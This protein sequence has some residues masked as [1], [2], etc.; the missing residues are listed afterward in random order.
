MMGTIPV[1]ARRVMAGLRDQGI[2]TSAKGHG[3]GWMID[4]DP[5]ARGFG[6]APAACQCAPSSRIR[7]AR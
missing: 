6:S 4:C 3:G 7:R 1:V 2:V 5:A